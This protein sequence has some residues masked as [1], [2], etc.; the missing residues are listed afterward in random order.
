[1]KTI[2]R[3]LCPIDLTPE[4]EEALRYAVVLAERYD[5]LL[6]V[7]H[8]IE[9]PTTPIEELMENV[10]DSITATVDRW[11]KVGR[12][13]RLRWEPVILIG[14]P[15]E[16][17]NRVAL[18][19]QADL[20]VIRSQQGAMA[21]RLFGSTAE[22]VCH[23]S[24]CSVLVTHPNEREWAGKFTREIDLKRVLVAYDFSVDAE[25]ALAYG[26]SF[27]QEYQTELHLINICN[28]ESPGEHDQ[29]P[30]IEERLR[31]TTPDEVL[32]WCKVQYAV[33]EGEP[34]IQIISYAKDH[35]ID[36]ICMGI[37][38]SGP[39]TLNPFGST[40]DRVLHQSP[41][42]VLIARPAIM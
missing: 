2:K 11:S 4:S 15:V 9:K 17:I 27:S 18:E 34:H 19:N 12:P 3:I 5:A 38:G 1:M 32:L 20:I 36:L 30:Q 23:S 25:L 29:R 16:Q 35:K 22:S 31:K 33:L 26:F 37:K 7:L 24:P 40:V 8:S 10:K 41:C 39:K 42:P 28:P 6:F 13:T 21:A 14:N